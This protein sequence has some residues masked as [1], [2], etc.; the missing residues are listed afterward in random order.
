ME[1]NEQA[2]A[3]K[4]GIR[5]GV[6]LP[7]IVS[8]RLISNAG[9][10]YPAEGFAE[11]RNLNK[12]AM[13]GWQ[14]NPYQ[15]T[16][17][18]IQMQR[19]PNAYMPD[20]PAPQQ[21]AGPTAYEEMKRAALDAEREKSSQLYQKEKAAFEAA[22]KTADDVILAVKAAVAAGDEK[23]YAAALEAAKTVDV[24]GM[25]EQGWGELFSDRGKRQRLVKQLSTMKAPKKPDAFDQMYKRSLIKSRK[26]DLDARKAETKR[27]AAAGKMLIKHR[28]ALVALAKRKASDQEVRTE[29]LSMAQGLRELGFDQEQ[30]LKAAR[31]SLAYA[32]AAAARERAKKSRFDRSPEGLKAAQK[33]ARAQGGVGPRQMLALDQKIAGVKALISTLEEAKNQNRPLT[34]ADLNQLNTSLSKED[35]EKMR[36][37]VK[38]GQSKSALEGA[39]TKLREYQAL[40]GKINLPDE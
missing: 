6:P 23:A 17:S 4:S 34:D 7:E 5:Q 21:P 30:A 16:T 18:G 11:R 37:M 24:S 31:E 25:K 27:K 10:S 2:L 22:P 29:V 32:S 20:Q 1:Q 14:Q 36:R 28:N 3:N 8:D 26:G 35:A 33:R 39:Y 13:D 40:R 15:P 12:S 19:Q 9:G 38:T